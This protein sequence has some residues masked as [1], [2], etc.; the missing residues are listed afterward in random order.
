MSKSS[1]MSESVG[2]KRGSSINKVSY[3]LQG[4]LFL[5]IAVGIL[6]FG[7]TNGTGVVNDMFRRGEN[8]I[9]LENY[10]GE[11]HKMIVAYE[12]PPRRVLVTYPGATELLITLGLENRIVATMKP[13]G[14]EPPELVSAY[15]LLPKLEAP[16][17][18]TKEE[19]LRENPD[20]VMAWNHHFLPNALG[21]VRYW[22]KRGIATYIVPATVRKGT[23]TMEGTVFPFIDNIGVIFDVEEEA[24]KYKESLANR[25]EVVRQ[26]AIARGTTPTVMVL[27]LH[28]NSVYTVYGESYII[29]DIV[30]TAGGHPLVPQGMSFVGPERILGVDPD[31]IVLV[32][33]DYS[34][35]METFTEEGMNLVKRDSNI[36]HMR[37]VES[38]RVIPVPFGAIN[39]G[40]GR[41]VDA[42]E[43]ISAGFNR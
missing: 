7:I 35:H 3:V 32:M 18:P 9:Q 33:T 14:I 26:D 12:V 34:G 31:F 6:W 16:F 21:D 19:V 27:Q 5:V 42:L 37:A 8:I 23:P 28:G 40:N 15:D 39:N 20:L 25:I 1:V 4:L 38:G 10:T 43:M 11:G 22:H 24:A 36:R 13:Y 30:R 41:V 17:V 29:H 2:M